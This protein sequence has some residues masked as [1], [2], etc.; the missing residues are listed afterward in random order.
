MNTGNPI[1]KE[2]IEID[3][4][5]AYEALNIDKNLPFILSFGGSG[6]QKVK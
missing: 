2:I 1:R 4:E 3:K 5:K 6:G